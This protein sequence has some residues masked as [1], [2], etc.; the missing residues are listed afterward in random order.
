MDRVNSPKESWLADPEV[1]RINREDAH[2][3]HLYYEEKVHEYGVDMPLRQY[4]NGTWK[5]SYAENADSRIRDFYTMEYDVSDFGDIRVPG[6]IELAGYDRCQYINTMY[7][8]EGHEDLRPPHIPVK[9]NPVSAYVTYFDVEEALKGKRTYISFQGV[10]RAFYV[11][12]NGNFVGYSE[13]SFT[14]SEFDITDFIREKNN[15]LAVEVYKHSSASWLED[16]DFFRFSGIFR[17]V[18]LYAVPRTHIRDLFVRA[19]LDENYFDGRLRLVLDIMGETAGSLGYE[20]VDKTGKTVLTRMGLALKEHMELQAQVPQVLKWSAELPNLYLLNISVYD[21]NGELVE[22]VPQR[23]GFRRVEIKNGIICINGKRIIFKGVN[24]HEFSCVNGRAVTKKEM[25]EDIRIIK[26]LNINAVRTS[27]Y[28]NQTYWYEL[29]DEFGLYLIDEANLETHGTWCID[30]GEEEPYIVPG[31]EPVWREAVLDRARSMLER[32]KNHPC[33]LIWSCGNEAHAGEDILAMSRFFHERNPERPVHYESCVH[34]RRFSDITDMESRMYAKPAEIEE[35]LKGKP[36]KPYLSCEYMH[37]MGNSCGGM[38]K[39]TELEYKYEQYQGGFIWDFADQAILTKDG[40]LIREDIIGK[41]GNVRTY[42]KLPGNTQ[43][44]LEFCVGGDFGDRPCDYYFSG[45]GIVFADRRLSPKA[46]EVKYLYQNIK[47]HMTE[48][49]VLIVNENLFESTEDYVFEVRLLRDGKALWAGTFARDVAA[50]EE[51]FVPVQ[52]PAMEEPGEY[53]TECRAILMGYRPWANVGHVAAWGQSAPYMVKEGEKPGEN[54]ACEEA[55]DFADVVMGAVCIGVK[56][57]TMEA[58]FSRQEGGM[59][60]LSCKGL[61]MIERVPRLT[62]FRAATDNDK[63]NNFAAES[64]L[65]MGISQLQRCD[66]VTVEYELKDGRVLDGTRGCGEFLLSKG[67]E[68]YGTGLKGGELAKLIAAVKIRCHYTL[69]TNPAAEGEITYR[70]TPEGRIECAGH[71][72]GKPGLPGL[73]VFGVTFGMDRSFGRIEYYG[74]GPEENYNDRCKGARLGIYK[75]RAE[76]N[77]TPYLNPQECGNRHDVRWVKVVDEFGHGIRID[78]VER[79]FD[80]TVLPYTAFE[81]QNAC[82]VN[83]L[84]APQLTHVSILGA[85]RGVGGDDS[86]GAPVHEEFCVQSDREQRVEF[87]ITGL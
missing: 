17:D 51:E 36:E 87:V 54:R 26:S 83:Q 69:Y 8:W 41:Y 43:G 72:T 76:D 75:G 67:D 49:G 53:I 78:A 12:L 42:E 79:P 82:K 84:P 31:S 56:T 38:F 63:G 4:L 40:E 64:A 61:E 55:P 25:E 11:W 18:Y 33:V 22:Y 23:I 50:G 81:L 1:F 21:E 45:N 13:D 62:F 28:P 16:Q 15:K 34:D 2:S 65:W 59:I 39:Y 19:E 48:Q 66:K 68:G 60:S 3:D 37:A 77:V 35:Y 24:R 14:P 7:P 52:F 74:R 47:L 86:W 57:R 32:D 9:H 5:Y 44:S 80:M 85:A 27:H 58:V 29:C 71:Y 73:P 30:T 70:M 46:Q 20:L 10:E 6:H